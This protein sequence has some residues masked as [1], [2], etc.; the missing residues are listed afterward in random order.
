LQ[1]IP[2]EKPNSY[3]MEDG[4]TAHTANYSINVLNKVFEDKLR[5]HRLWPVMSPH[6][7]PCDRYLLATSY[8][9]KK[10]SV[11]K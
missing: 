2:E 8:S 11:L 7:N 9:P 6:L 5:S 10:Q 3:F 1:R 4:A